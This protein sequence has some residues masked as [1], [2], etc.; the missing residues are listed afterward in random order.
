MN[1]L[2]THPFFFRCRDKNQRNEMNHIIMFFCAKERERESEWEM[3]RL[4]V[5]VGWL[6]GRSVIRDKCVS[7]WMNGVDGLKQDN[8]WIDHDDQPQIV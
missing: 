2:C 3:D 5:F 6:V 8:Y 1:L 4:V 7:G